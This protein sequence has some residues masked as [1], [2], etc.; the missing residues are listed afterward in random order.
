M[1]KKQ[2]KKLRV[3]TSVLYLLFIAL[4]LLMLKVYSYIKIVDMAFLVYYTLLVAVIRIGYEIIK[5]ESNEQ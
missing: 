1:E 3:K 4:G 2:V 5:R